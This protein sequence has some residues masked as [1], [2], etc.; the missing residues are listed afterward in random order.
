MLLI[1]ENT[2][3]L[4]VVVVEGGIIFKDGVDLTFDAHYVIV[5]HGF[6]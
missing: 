6:F 2:P 1:D 4:G 3:I 5:R